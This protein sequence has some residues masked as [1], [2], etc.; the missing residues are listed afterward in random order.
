MVVCLAAAGGGIRVGLGQREMRRFTEVRQAHLV[1]SRQAARD[2]VRGRHRAA[3][4][5][6]LTQCVR[7][8]LEPHGQHHTPHHQRGE[9]VDVTKAEHRAWW[10]E[11]KGGV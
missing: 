6:Q 4:T 10:V 9:K 7:S 2:A 3:G 8:D 5:Q 1:E 11:G